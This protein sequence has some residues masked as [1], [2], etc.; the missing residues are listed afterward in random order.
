MMM[1]HQTKFG[2]RKICS[3]E[4]IVEKS[5]FD[6][7]SPRRDPDLED[8]KYVFSAWHSGSRCCITIPSLVTK[9]SVVQNVSSKQTFTDILNCCCDLDLECSNPIFP[10]DTLAYDALL[11]NQVWLQKDEQF[12][13]YRGNSHILIIKALAMTL[14][15]QT[16]NQFFC[17]IFL[18][19]TLHDHTKF[20][21]K[22]ICGSEDIIQTNIH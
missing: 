18:L 22:V 21:S 6:Q 5:H 7:M 16:V 19:M 3:S 10:Q 20:G 2:C 9:C 11:L 15:S 17:L 13:T 12:K 14:T 8:S 1:Y 4:D